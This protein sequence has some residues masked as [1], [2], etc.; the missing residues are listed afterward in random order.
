MSEQLP[1]EIAP[2]NR[3]LTA[4]EF[5]RLADVGL[6][7]AVLSEFFAMSI[8]MPGDAPGQCAPAIDSRTAAA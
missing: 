3:L 8:S 6:A 5:H 4:A 7:A 1:A 2:T